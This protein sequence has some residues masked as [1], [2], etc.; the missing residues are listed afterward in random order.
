MA[1]APDRSIDVDAVHELLADSR[2]RRL[3]KH[4]RENRRATLEECVLTAAAANGNEPLDETQDR[5]RVSLVHNHLPRLEDH[6]VIEYDRENGDVTATPAIAELE[7][8]LDRLDEADVDGTTG[9][10]VVYVP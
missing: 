6:G 4:L 9:R 1:T 8:V 3:V 7:P 5:V 2:R 10:S